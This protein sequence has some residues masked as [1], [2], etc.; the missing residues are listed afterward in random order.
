MENA[1]K[2]G[3]GMIYPHKTRVVKAWVVCS[4]C[5]GARHRVL[6]GEKTPWWFCQD[7]KQYLKEGQEIE[8]EDIK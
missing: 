1:N 2:G 8:L 6:P 5:N 3:T 7:E 4:K